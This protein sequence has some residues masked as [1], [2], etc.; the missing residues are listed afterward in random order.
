VKSLAQ[1]RVSIA[2][3]LAEGT[4]VNVNISVAQR[5]LHGLLTVALLKLHTLEAEHVTVFVGSG[6]AAVAD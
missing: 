5:L 4:A 1:H 2:L 3:R 6:S